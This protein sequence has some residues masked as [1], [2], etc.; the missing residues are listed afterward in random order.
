MRWGGRWGGAH[1]RWFIPPEQDSPRG[2]AFQQQ[3]RWSDPDGWARQASPCRAGCDEV[4]ECD[5]G[6]KLMGVGGLAAVAGVVGVVALR[7][8]RR[9][10]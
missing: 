9:L 1:A 6:E 5:G 2:P 7:R 8:R 3:G 10:T 4:G